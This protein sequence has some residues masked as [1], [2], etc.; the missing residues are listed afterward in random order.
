MKY[1]VHIDI[2]TDDRQ[3][4]EKRIIDILYGVPGDEHDPDILM[5]TIEGERQPVKDD[6]DAKTG[7]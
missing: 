6:G 7:T 2:D 1:I 4:G 5:F 3:A